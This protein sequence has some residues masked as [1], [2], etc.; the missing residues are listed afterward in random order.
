MPSASRCY[1]ASHAERDGSLL[2]VLSGPSGVGKDTVLQQVRKLEPGIWY[3]ITATTR[4]PRQGERDGVDYYFLNH[5]TF[6]RLKAN[7]G[8]LENAQVHG[9]SY[10]VPCQQVAGALARRQDVLAAVDV[11]GARTIH[12]RIPTSILIFLAPGEHE[13]LRARLMGRGTESPTDLDVRL[14]NAQ[15]ELAHASEFDYLVR[16]PDGRVHQAVNQVV[17][18]IRAERLRE[19]PRFAVLDG[20]CGG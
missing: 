3:C 6:E 9:H 13:D 1:L 11:Q 14:A 15:A 12:A 19:S 18:I 16:N 4:L 17:D 5:E 2:F 8:L 20:G 10:G 7:G